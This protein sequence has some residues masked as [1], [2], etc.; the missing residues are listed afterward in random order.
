MI[1]ARLGDLQ[2]YEFYSWKVTE[3]ISNLGSDTIFEF[4]YKIKYSDYPA[5]ETLIVIKSK[6]NGK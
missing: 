5:T 2:E 4:Q 1:N 6:D 3:R